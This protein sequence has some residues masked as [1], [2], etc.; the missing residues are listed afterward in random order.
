M[1]VTNIHMNLK[2][3]YSHTCQRLIWNFKKSN[4]NTIKKSIELVN[5]DFL[6]SNKSV[7]QQVIILNQTLMS[8][9]SNYVP[10]KLIRFKM[11]KILHG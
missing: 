7:H 5:W 2:I 1:T 6:F 9:V 8:I 10:N 11:I 3:E 4:F